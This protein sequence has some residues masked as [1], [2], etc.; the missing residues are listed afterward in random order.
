MLEKIREDVKVLMGS[1]DDGHGFE[2]IERVYNLAMEIAKKEK[3]DLEVVALAALLHDADD[4]KLVGQE[5][6]DNL[7]NTKKIMQDNHVDA[8]VQEKVCEIIKNMGYSKALKGIRPQNLEGKIVSD[9]DMLDAI[10]AVSVVRTLS[11]SLS[12]GKVIFDKN[13]FPE[14]NLSA[15]SYKLTERKTDSFI[16]HFFDKLLKLKNMMLTNAAYEEALVRQKVMVDFLDAFFRE[17]NCSEWNEYLQDY[18]EE[19]EKI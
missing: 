6:A 18:C 13:I 10:G 15:E 16:N 11:Y 8:V 1:D 17:N 4:Y 2:H 12:K 14:S 7:T 9:A 5:C 3:A 19:M